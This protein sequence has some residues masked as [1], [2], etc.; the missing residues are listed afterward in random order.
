MAG[1]VTNKEIAETLSQ[2]LGR[3]VDY[4]EIGEEEWAST[5][6]ALGVN[7]VA[8]EHLTHL[9]RYLRT[10]PL[11]HQAFYHVTDAFEDLTGE[12]PKSL[13][14]FLQEH[15]DLFVQAATR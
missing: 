15:K 1:A 9:W 7:A 2:I 8:V 13:A 10:L 4:I 6:S 3:S 12:P 14:H 5:V 11:E